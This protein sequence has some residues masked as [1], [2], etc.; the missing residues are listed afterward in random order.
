MSISRFC[1]A[2]RRAALAVGLVFTAQTFFPALAL[3]ADRFWV[4]PAG[5]AFAASP[6]HW[7]VSQGGA[8]GAS[9]PSTGDIANFTLNTAYTVTFGMSATNQQ[10]HVENGTVTFD[11]LGQTYTH[12]TLTGTAVGNVAGQTARLTVTGGTM[13]SDTS[14]DLVEIGAVGS[15]TG[16]LTLSTAARW[17]GNPDVVVGT[18]GDGNLTIENGAD[19]AAT[20]SALGFS[21]GGL[22]TAI[23]T[24]IGSTW[25]SAAQFTVGDAG[26]GIL[27]VAAGAQ[28]SSATAS[29]GFD[30]TGTGAVLVADAG[31]I[32]SQS[33]ALTIAEEG[34][35][36]LRV[37]NGGR[38]ASGSAVLG[39]ATTGEGRATIIGPT[40]SWFVADTLVI[41]ALGQGTL[42]VSGGGQLTSGAATIGANAAGSGA[43]AIRGTDSN[44]SASG[45]IAIGGTGAATM[46]VSE[47]GAVTATG[48]LSINDPAGAPV[49]TLNLA[50]GS[51]TAQSVT[52][53]G[54]LNWTDGTLTVFGGTFNNG[55]ANLTINGGD[56]DDLPT[57]H[58]AGGATGANFAATSLTL[59]ASRRGA[60]A[61]TGGSTLTVTDAQLGSLDGGDG[62]L[63]VS[64]AG[65]ELATTGN[66]AIGGTSAAAGGSGT[67]NLNS[68]G[69]LRVDGSL[70]LWPGGTVAV[71]GGTLRFATL[72]PRGGKI[73]LSAGK[74]QF[75][76]SQTLGQGDG[77]ADAILGPAR[78]LGPG[79][80][81]EAAG[82]SLTLA[83]NLILSGGRLEGNQL[84]VAAGGELHSTEPTSRIDNASLRNQ[85]I[86]S[87]SGRVAST[88]ENETTG[89]VRATTGQRLVFSGNGNHVNNGL[90]D[91]AGGAIEFTGPVRNNS[92][93]PAAGSI[94][95]RNG[96]LRFHGGLTNSGSMV[97]SNGTM[98]IFGDINNVAAAPTTGRI[99]VS[100]GGAANFYDDIIN[101][102]TIQ[103]SAA[104]SLQSA[105]V[106]FGALSGNGVSGTGHVFI[107]GDARPG[108]SPGT[109]DFGGDVSFSPDATLD[110]EIGGATPGT[111]H[112][113]V[114]VS[115][116]AALAGTLEVT[117]V[118][119]FVPASG[120]QFT[121]MSYG[122]HTGAF[123]TIST[124]SGPRILWNATYSDTALT[125]TA[126]GLAG[127]MNLD[128]NVN[129]LDLSLFARHFGTRS[130][131]TI[132][133]GDFNHDGRTSLADLVIL[134]SN[135]GARLPAAQMVQAIPEPNTIF[136]AWTILFIVAVSLIA[137]RRAPFASNLP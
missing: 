129:S 101:G 95:G 61:V 93:N 23:V 36:A 1:G 72:D 64:G 35:G 99:V 62:T 136:V 31:S 126:Q 125:L 51:I 4:T 137:S 108:F 33:G 80:T 19:I 88:L 10:L 9:V 73:N 90:I 29:I 32:W 37:Q 43:V 104:G 103:V 105:A 22:G 5:G 6:T 109:M 78:I 107:E 45:A 124:M 56:A 112:D 57:L 120:Q 94:A 47:G 115:D 71:D 106:F 12:T 100:G 87:G 25:T 13:R 131:A 119:G 116:L 49:G 122:S 98:D 7:S 14:N 128:G 53:A 52:R 40:S 110:I 58:M 82:P 60:L 21:V 91:L 18:S 79:Q 86:L 114:T 41:G 27:S 59:G 39:N 68:S 26:T 15:S 83:T 63:A 76:S 2:A 84:I 65:S 50:G 81:L 134:R 85:G 70:R 24:G 20:D 66:L 127:D 28:V 118:G 102:G 44:W 75:A 48:S 123:D 54:A 117:L 133:E 67:I 92:Q 113:R 132:R 96:V 111:Q 69:R 74:I 121:I 89:Q 42:E 130:G 16:H 135:L 97:F 77:V 38:A 8:S 11:L 55:G 17:I 30:P 3:G 34:A 46:T